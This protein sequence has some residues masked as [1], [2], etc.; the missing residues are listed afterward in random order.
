MAEITIS[1]TEYKELIK[2]TARI[3]AFAQYVNMERYSISREI[4]GVF[5]GFE[6][7]ENAGED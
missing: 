3:E 7:E 2:N 6:V 5:F 1:D 4:C